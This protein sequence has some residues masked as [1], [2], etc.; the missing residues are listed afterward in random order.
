[1]AIGHIVALLY[2][3]ESAREAIRALRGFMRRVYDPQ[4]DLTGYDDQRPIR[5]WAI[6]TTDMGRVIRFEA[7]GRL[8]VTLM[9]WGL[10]PYWAKD[11][12]IG[13]KCVNA[14][15]ETIA[16]TPTYRDAFKQ[17]RC[18]VP[19]TAWVE[20]REEQPTGANRPFKQ[21]YRIEPSDGAPF[22]F[23][24]LWESWR[25][26]NPDGSRG[27]P[28]LSYTIA[29]CEPSPWAARIHNRMP[30]V[31]KP[32]DIEAWLTAPANDVAALLKAYTG[33]L[34]ARP[35]HRDIANHR[36]ATPGSINP[37]GPPLSDAA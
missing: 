9:R 5:P 32:E 2:T 14:R 27:D 1:V 33:P 4:G 18:L 23:A 24:G 31:L 17:R 10:V 3:D 8:S 19:A 21:P 25:P 6:R 16:T 34:M 12:D 11:L 7:D 22:V 13:K 29:T 37:I 35:I 36:V 20:W 15:A 28:V 30:V 26:K